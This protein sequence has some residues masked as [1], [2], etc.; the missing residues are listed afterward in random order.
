M[1]LNG[2]TVMLKK[3]IVI[4]AAVLLVGVV[5]KAETKPLDYQNKRAL[6]FFTKD[7]NRYLPKFE[8]ITLDKTKELNG[9]IERLENR[10]SK[11]TAKDHPDVIAAQK[12]VAALKAKLKGATKGGPSPESILSDQKN[13]KEFQRLYQRNRVALDV[14]S[15]ADLSKPAEAKRWKKV[16]KEFA[17]VVGKFQNKDNP[18]VKKDLQ[19]YAKIKAKVESGLAGS[20]KVDIKNYP[21]FKQ[22]KDFLNALYKKYSMNKI[23]SKGNEA[24]AKRLLADYDN[25]KKAYDKLDKK[26]AA[27]IE[28]NKAAYTP[29]YKQAG[30]MKRSLRNAGQWIGKFTNAKKEFVAESG[31][32]IEKL[33]TK[34]REK[35]TK[36]V[37]EK[38]PLWF[39]GGGIGHAMMQISGQLDSL[40]AIKGKND[41][42]VKALR[43]KFV[44]LSSQVKKAE[45][46]LK[47]S[48]LA[49]TKM[50]ANAYSGG[51]KNKIID[52]AV[53]EWNKKHSK[54][55][56]L[57][58]GIS[59]PNWERRT[60]WRYH[61]V[62]GTHY[63]VDRSYLQVWVIIKTSD[64]LAT[65][66]FIELSKNHM[67]G[68]SIT[69]NVPTNLQG[70]VLKTEM[71]LKNVK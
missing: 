31:P 46:D 50:P 63:K 38:R 11:L 68:D 29:G 30:E 66:Y 28:G 60:E 12:K 18:D 44:N 2:D 33:M 49:A 59:M 42:Q 35:V 52:L 3:S 34:T 32:R 21:K 8:K 47:E 40:A 17:D 56:V 67:Q 69:I 14:L 1:V 55:P 24:A 26:Y 6:R 5:A 27:F 10:L 37:K 43:G 65:Q 20:G 45:S 71:L 39:T 64:K 4:I 23:F 25:D 54:K 57:A 9:Y 70:D 62:N 13:H 51:D 19:L 48:I 53:K 16:L 41:S 61:S 36:A 22:D 7:Y 58:K 15:P